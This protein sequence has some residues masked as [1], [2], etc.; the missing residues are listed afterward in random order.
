MDFTDIIVSRRSIRKYSGK[1]VSDGQLIKLIKSGMYAPSTMNKQP[2]Y[3]IILRDHDVFKEIIEVHPHS[4][5]LKEASAAILVCRDKNK[6]HLPEYGTQDCA[7]CTQNILLAAHSSGLGAV[8][9]GIYP[10]KERI[11]KIISLLNIPSG[12]EPFSLIS[13]GY[14]GEEKDLPDRFHLDRIFFNKW[15]E[16]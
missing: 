12:I 3:F 10:R 8:W 1:E 4:K 6:E 5:M 11:T 2:W 16:K 13:V 7:A 14:P 15:G 9:L